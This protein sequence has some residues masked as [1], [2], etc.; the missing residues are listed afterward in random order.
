MKPAQSVEVSFSL[1]FE[2]VNGIWWRLLLP[3]LSWICKIFNLLPMVVI[4]F[5]KSMP[6][7]LAWPVSKQKPNNSV[8]YLSLRRSILSAAFRALQQELSIKCPPISSWIFSMQAIIPSS[9]SW[10]AILLMNASV[11][12]HSA[13]SE[14]RYFSNLKP[15]ITIY[16]HS[17]KEQTFK[18]F[19][20]TLLIR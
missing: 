18:L 13:S 16:L 8:L 11:C 2:N 3:S 7:T 10:G 17:R 6:S 9:L 20:A 19:G 4:N 5:S 14:P 15:C 1:D 12:C